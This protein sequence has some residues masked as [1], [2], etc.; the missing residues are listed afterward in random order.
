MGGILYLM[1]SKEVATWLQ[2]PAVKAAFM[3][4]Y[5]GVVEVRDYGHTLIMEYVPV[6][7]DTSSSRDL[8]EVEEVNTLPEGDLMGAKWLKAVERRS[9]N[10]ATAFLALTVKSPLT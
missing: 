2:Q 4:H 1:T 6:R 8:R 10:Q 7:F 5:G 9:L 3:E